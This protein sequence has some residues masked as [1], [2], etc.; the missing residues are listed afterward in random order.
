MQLLP[1]DVVRPGLGHE[2]LVADGRE[3]HD[4]EEHGHRLDP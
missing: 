2:E 1:E 4:A 3:H